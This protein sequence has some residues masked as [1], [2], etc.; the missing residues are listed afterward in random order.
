M[1]APNLGATTLYGE[2][3]AWNDFGVRRSAVAL[4]FGAASEITDTSADMW[5]I[6]LV[7]DIDAASMKVFT[8]M[9]YWDHDVRVAVPDQAAA[10]HDVPLEQLLAVTVGGRIAF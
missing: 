1:L 6:G 5:G 9:R 4:G 8:A 2:Y 10:G 3:Q 7:Q